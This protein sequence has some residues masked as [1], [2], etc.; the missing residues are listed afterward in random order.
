MP[1]VP[2]RSAVEVVAE[3]SDVEPGLQKKRGGLP[4]RNLKCDLKTLCVRRCSD[5]GAVILEDF[6]RNGYS[7]L[8]ASLCAE[9]RC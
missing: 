5:T 1:D 3:A 6:R 2:N 8:S 7:D 9:I 4:V